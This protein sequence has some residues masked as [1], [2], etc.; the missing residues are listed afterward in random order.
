MSETKKSV[1]KNYIYNLIYQILT[2]LL[3]IVTTPYLSRVLGAENIGI[4]SYTYSITT[5]FI[6]IGSL[7][8]SLYGQREIA[9]LQNDKY[10]RSKTFWEIAILKFVTTSISMIIFFFAFIMGTQYNFYYGLLSL[11]LLSTAIEIIWFFQGLEEFKKTVTRNILVKLF[12]FVSIFIFVKN[13]NDLWKYFLIYGLSEVL[14]NITLWAYLP[15]YICKVKL[16]DL[17]I[18]KHIKPTL[19]LFIPQISSQIYAMLDKTMLGNVSNSKA[20]VGYYEQ[21][22]KIINLCV[23]VVT[24]LGTVLIPRIASVFSTG[25]IKKLKEYIS[26]SFKFTYFLALPMIFGIFIVADE[27]VPIFFGNGYER[28]AIIL[29]VISP[30]I[31]LTGMT[32]VIGK[33]FLL[34]TKKE[35][36]YTIAI[37]TGTITNG[38]LNYIFIPYGGAVAASITTIIGEIVILIIELTFTRK[39]IKFIKI[40]KSCWKYLVASIMMLSVCE[41]IK[42][43]IIGSIFVSIP[44]AIIVYVVVLLLT[45]DDILN[46]I[47]KKV[48]KFF[49]KQ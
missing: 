29:K 16:R 17:N 24:S 20:E 40:I 45:K 25:N 6:I 18:L 41:V 3:P 4:Y 38:V 43:F 27:F 30:I 49:K 19:T 10:K 14:G 47:I 32:N 26:K 31:L 39:N 5:Y 44:V 15:K 42:H 9:Y 8:I 1:T 11:N 33:Q 35:K 7:G 22:Q 2:I 46:E 36:I 21:A 48:L 37:I 13:N 34:P 12:C 23:A 28:V